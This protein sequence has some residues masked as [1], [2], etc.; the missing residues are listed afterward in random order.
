VVIREK[1]EKAPFFRPLSLACL[2]RCR[3]G[4]LPFT[5]ESFACSRAWGLGF[6]T[7][8]AFHAP[9]LLSPL[10]CRLPAPAVS[11][12]S[13]VVVPLE[14]WKEDEGGGELVVGIFTSFLWSYFFCGPKTKLKLSDVLARKLRNMSPASRRGLARPRPCYHAPLAIRDF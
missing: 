1:V 7:S 4:G 2:R 8:S 9:R 13:L 11:P 10:I 6:V 3:P 12:M 5:V 14:R